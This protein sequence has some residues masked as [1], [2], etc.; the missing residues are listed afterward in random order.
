MRREPVTADGSMFTF[1]DIESLSNAFTLCAY[2]PVSDEPCVH[3][4]EA[5]YLIDDAGLLADLNAQ[6]LYDTIVEANP[7]MGPTSLAVHDL[8]T[9]AGA[10]RLAELVGAST[11]DEVWNRASYSRLPARLRP[12]CDTDDDYDP[13]RHPFLAGYNS[14]NYD[15]VMLAHFLAESFPIDTSLQPG[16]EFQPTTAATLRAHNDELYTTYIDYM[17]KALGYDSPAAIFRRNMLASGRH[18]DVARL[19]E[20]QFK[21]ALKRQLGMLG[22]QIL[23][24]EKLSHNSV[25]TCIEDLYD[26]LAYNVSDC[27][28]L[29]QLFQNPT[30]RDAFDLKAGLI[31]DYGETR[32]N[33]DDSVRRDRLSIDSSSAKLVGRIL[34]PFGHL[35]DAPVVSFDYPHPVIA[36]QRGVPVTNVLDDTERFFRNNIV[37]P[38]DPALSDHQRQAWEQ[39]SKVLEFYRDI[40][41]KN[42]NDSAEYQNKHGYQRPAHSLSEIAKRPLNVPYFRADGSA[43]SCFVTFSTGGIHGAE[44]NT[45]AHE[46]LQRHYELERLEIQRAKM[47]FKDVDEFLDAAKEQHNRLH[48]PD[49]TIV[50]KRLVL[51]GSSPEKVKYR[52]PKAGKTPEAEHQHQQLFAAQDQLPDAADLLATQREESFR[53]DVELDSKQVLHA[54]TVLT[55]N[56]KAFREEPPTPR[57]S[58]FQIKDDGANTV[59]KRFTRTSAG[60][61]VHEDFTSYYPNLL[62]NMRAFYNEMLGED[63]YANI[64]FQKEELGQKLKNPNLSDEARTTL[65][66]ARNGTKLVLNSASGAG[67]ASHRTPIRMN[68][69]IIAMRII[70]QLLTWRIGQAQTLVGGRIISTNTDGLYSV[71]D[72]DGTFDVATNNR[73]LDEQQAAIGVDIEPELMFLIS[74]DS[75]NRMELMPPRGAPELADTVQPQKALRADGSFA[76]QDLEVTAA[77]GGSLACYQGPLA[78]KS[79]SHPA[80]LD[81]G[82]AHYLQRLVVGGEARLSEEFDLQLGRAVIEEA[83]DHSDPVQTLRMFQ[84][85]LAASPGSITYPFAATHMGAQVAQE[86]AE[87][88][89][90]GEDLVDPRPLQMYNRVFVVKEGTPGAVNLHMAAAPKIPPA[91]L[92]TRAKNGQAQTRHDTV[93]QQMLAHHGWAATRADR[94]EHPDLRLIP[95]DRDIAVR[96]IN[97]IDPRWPMRILNDD[98]H[99]LSE[100]AA[101]ALIESLDLTIYTQMLEDTFTKNWRNS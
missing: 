20:V 71:I 37:D 51:I 48:L 15:T 7:S 12:V 43:D 21:V 76:I 4:L 77:G 75:N 39:F 50:D 91:S 84:N 97:G 31:A 68:N 54:K 52:N 30:Y 87:G 28:G 33:R 3:M 49:G 23:E 94:A 22:R 25:L 93:A 36:E 27:V 47:C 5:F 72:H 1:Y 38:D 88:G 34:S 90:D 59:D 62:R 66:N 95:E 32:F 14:Q 101:G 35:D 55:S 57:P 44:T 45:S 65:S 26:L 24:S 79:L 92:Q 83:I 17:P 53:Y 74:K 18:L 99:C 16:P 82:L 11:A 64:Y 85:V 67:D 2:T 60:L 10:Y 86:Q 100:Q 80:V 69:V 6:K 58:I 19:N 98:L 13:M 8:S 41:G 46:Q 81:R 89:T 29:A 56:R 70:G 63:R 78:T 73:V 42:F 96:K 61:V 40:E 9:A